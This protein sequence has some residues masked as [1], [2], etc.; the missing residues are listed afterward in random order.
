LCDATY[1]DRSDDHAPRATEKEQTI[2]NI[3]L[4]HEPEVPVRPWGIGVVREDIEIAE[5][6]KLAQD[7]IDKC[8]RVALIKSIQ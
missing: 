1:E 2:D 3:K 7:P 5:H 6:R 4:K 8:G